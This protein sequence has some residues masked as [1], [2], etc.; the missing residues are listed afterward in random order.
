[1][2]SIHFVQV[3]KRCD[4][5][6]LLY[7]ISILKNDQITRLMAT[8]IQRVLL[9][10]LVLVLRFVTLF[11][12]FSFCQ[13]NS[14]KSNN[15]SFLFKTN[16]LELFGV[17]FLSMNGFLLFKECFQNSFKRQVFFQHLLKC[18]VLDHSHCSVYLKCSLL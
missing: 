12:T 4:S 8:P 13:T 15:P 3:F 1:M 10:V 11:L 7:C 16:L 2:K 6:C 14:S 9:L 5:H 17:L 18:V